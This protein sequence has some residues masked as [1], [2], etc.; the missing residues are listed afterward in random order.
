MENEEKKKSSE[1]E[2]F[3]LRKPLRRRLCHATSKIKLNFLQILGSKL[4]V[5]HGHQHRLGPGVNFTNIFDMLFLRK[6]FRSFL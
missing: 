5:Q 1:K 2:V 6:C 4:F 3:T